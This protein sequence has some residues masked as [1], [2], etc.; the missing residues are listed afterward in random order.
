MKMQRR[1]VIGAAIGGAFAATLAP[2]GAVR[3]AEAPAAAKFVKPTAQA[4]LL[5]C[6]NENPLGLSQEARAHLVP[7]LVRSSC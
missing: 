2:Q 3:A 4:P 5:A 7:H 6:F 1:Q